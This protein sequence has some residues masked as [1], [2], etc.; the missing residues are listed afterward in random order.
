MSG[1]IIA[2]CTSEHKGEAKAD[3][4][5]AEAVLD[6]GL[7]G[8]AHA[9]PGHRQISLL[10][11]ENIDEMRAKGLELLPGAFGENLVTSGFDLDSLSIGDHIRIGEAALFEVTQR[12]KEC[13]TPCAIYHQVGDCIMPRVGLFVRVLQ[14]GPVRN[15]DAVA[16]FGR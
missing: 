9:G 15:G 4:G 2:V 10:A 7:R 5:E 12:G 11:Q 13:H 3:V 14:G 16:R 6:S 1:Q 8:D